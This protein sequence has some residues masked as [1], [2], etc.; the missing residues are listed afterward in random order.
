[1]SDFVT[2]I[3]VLMNNDA[4]IN[5]AVSGGIHYENLIDNWL[6]NTNHNEWVVYE[7][8]KTPVDCLNSK[9]LFYNYT[10]N[11]VV[12]QR[13]SN[14]LVEYISNLIIDHL[15]GASYGGIQDI[16]FLTDD[17]GFNQQQG[18]Y[19]NSMSFNCIYVP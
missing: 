1:M 17:S 12:I 11:V 2:D 6:G 14:D 13:S 8:N 18:T 4:S 10:L 7:F 19:T 15:S 9:N 16:G 3:K 5:T